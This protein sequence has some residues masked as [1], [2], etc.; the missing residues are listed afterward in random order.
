MRQRGFERLTAH[1]HPWAAVPLRRRRRAVG[2]AQPLSQLSLMRAQYGRQV[3]TNRPSRY[4]MEPTARLD[5]ARSLRFLTRYSQRSLFLER[6]SFGS[7]LH[8]RFLPVSTPRFLSGRWNH[9]NFHQRAGLRP[10]APLRR[11]GLPTLAF[12]MRSLRSKPHPA[13]GHSPSRHSGAERAGG[14]PSRLPSSIDA[15]KSRLH[16]VRMNLRD[17]VMRRSRSF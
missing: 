12:P 7:V 3:V 2:A 17:E 5:L 1:R 11:Q 13:R 8:R 14:P 15:L 16:R 9:L 4:A 10:L 6:L